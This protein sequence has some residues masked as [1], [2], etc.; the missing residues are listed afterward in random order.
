MARLED[1]DSDMVKKNRPLLRR[2]AA[3]WK[4]DELTERQMFVY[5]K[6]F[7][8]P[9]SLEND[10]FLRNVTL[11]KLPASPMAL[12]KGE[13]YFFDYR[14]PETCLPH[15]IETHVQKKIAQKDLPKGTPPYTWTKDCE[16]AFRKNIVKTD[17][18]YSKTLEIDLLSHGMV[19]TGIEKGKKVFKINRPLVF[20]VSNIKL[21]VDPDCPGGEYVFN[22]AFDVNGHGVVNRHGIINSGQETV[23]NF[24]DWVHVKE[25]EKPLSSLVF[26][27]KVSPELKFDSLKLL[28][29]GQWPR[30]NMP[31]LR[32]G[33]NRIEWIPA[34]GQGKA[35][36]LVYNFKKLHGV[37]KDKLTVKKITKAH[38]NMGLKIAWDKTESTKL[39][40]YIVSYNPEGGVPVMP[41]LW[42]L[43][44]TKSFEIEKPLY[45][46]I[47]KRPLY[48]S[49]RPV[50]NNESLGEWSKPFRLN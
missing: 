12:F 1:I 33:V 49:V 45:D 43:S 28:I 23:F 42:N 50:F 8:P 16:G 40:E 6:Y 15:Y 47:K 44:E 14:L 35:I 11:K 30:G 29:S 5:N 37:N 7:T 27:F 3:S 18:M 39:Y 41:R 17:L 24:K 34:Q 36:E 21:V 9:H 20:P 26:S 31:P 2:S 10:F 19:S 32:P 13:K 48:V 4:G 46:E 22:A 38:S 25:I